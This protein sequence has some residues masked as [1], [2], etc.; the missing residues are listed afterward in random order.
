MPKIWKR[1]CDECGQYYEGGGAKFC[2]HSCQ[3]S[4]RN[5]RDNPAKRPEVRER[6]SR[7]HK[8]M[9]QEG[10]ITWKWRHN[11]NNGPNNPNWQGGVGGH[12]Y[13]KL[14]RLV[15]DCCNRC[16][17]KVDGYKRH[18]HHKNKDRRD[19]RIENL[20]LLCATCH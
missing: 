1:N 13:R 5:K 8:K 6:M 17:T 12:W 9:H 7:I 10:R 14:G 4:D 18:I 2:S 19:N 15:G 3:M 20:E 11:N 16:S